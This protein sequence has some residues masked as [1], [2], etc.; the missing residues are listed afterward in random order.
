MELPLQPP[1]TQPQ[2]PV[3][4]QGSLD[5]TQPR[6]PVVQQG[7]PGMGADVT[8]E[9]GAQ[10]VHS[11]EGVIPPIEEELRYDQQGR[12]RKMLKRQPEPSTAEPEADTT[13]EQPAAKPAK[14]AKAAK[15]AATK[16]SDEAPAAAPLKGAAKLDSKKAQSK[17]KTASATTYREGEL[18]PDTAKWLASADEDEA[19]AAK[20]D[21]TAARAATMADREKAAGQAAVNAAVARGAPS[22]PRGEQ[23]AQARAK[24][25]KPLG[26]FDTSKLGEKT[27]SAKTAEPV[28]AKTGPEIIE[29]KKPQA[30]G[31][32]DTSKLG[33]KAEAPAQMPFMITQLMKAQLRA[34]GYKSEAISNMTPADAHT[35]LQG[36]TPPKPVQ[37]ERPTVA[38]KDGEP[39]V[40]VVPPTDARLGGTKVS[41]AARKAGEEA[42]AV[43]ERKKKEAADKLAAETKP[44]DPKNLKDLGKLVAEKEAEPGSISDE[45]ADQSPRPKG[46]GT[47]N[48]LNQIEALSEEDVDKPDQPVKLTR[49]EKAI[50]AAKAIE[51]AKAQVAPNPTDAQKAAG[52]HQM[53]HPPT[54]ATQ[55]QHVTID[56][57]EGKIGEA[58][59]HILGTANNVPAEHLETLIRSKNDTGKFYVI[60]KLKDG[61]FDGHIAVQGATDEAN[62]YDAYI[63]KLRGEHPGMSLRERADRFS[64]VVAMSPTE[65]EHFKQTRNPNEPVYP[66]TEGQHP[67]GEVEI[68]EGVTAKTLGGASSSTAKVALEQAL[69]DLPND[70]LS[71]IKYAIYRK[72]AQQA[73]KYLPDVPIYYIKKSDLAKVSRKAAA[74]YNW[75]RN[76]ILISDEHVTGYPH[77]VMILHEVMHAAME[78][79]YS[80]NKNFRSAIDRIYGEYIDKLP[81]GEIPTAA[82]RSGGAA[83]FL[84]ELANP[85]VHDQMARIQMSKALAEDLDMGAWAKATHTLWN[86]VVKAY[87]DGLE[88][89]GFRIPG[90]DDPSKFTL[91]EGML[92]MNDE[93][94][95]LRNQ[96]ARTD[97]ANMTRA[98]NEH[99]NNIESTRAIEH[100]SQQDIIDTVHKAATDPESVER[101]SA[102]NGASISERAEDLLNK[103]PKGIGTEAYYGLVSKMMTTDLFRMANE[104][105][106][107]KLDESNPLRKY[108]EKT[109]Q[110]ARD[111]EERL[112]VK[113]EFVAKMGKATAEI[114][115]QETEK[116]SDLLSKA[117]AYRF[118]PRHAI[119]QGMNTWLKTAADRLAAARAKGEE[120]PNLFYKHQQAMDKSSEIINDFNN[121][122]PKAR[123]WY[124]R[125]VDDY[126]AKG[127]ERAE[128]TTDALLHTIDSEGKKFVEEPKLDPKNPKSKDAIDY[129]KYHND[130]E[131]NWEKNKA[132]L[133][134]RIL[135]DN[136]TENDTQ[137]LANRGI[138]ATDDIHALSVPKGPYVPLDHA[139]DYLINARYKINV[140]TNAKRINDNTFEFKTPEAMKEFLKNQPPNSRP[141]VVHYNDEG[142]VVPRV[143]NW[144]NADGSMG[145]AKDNKAWRV[146]VNDKY[147]SGH[148]N[149]SSANRRYEELKATGA[150]AKIAEPAMKQS[151]WYNQLEVSSPL[152]KKLIND[153]DKRTDYTADQKNAV[154]QLLTDTAIS[155]MEG[156]RIAKTLLPRKMVAGWDTDFIKTYDKYADMHNALMS[157]NKYA[158]EMGDIQNEMI[159]HTKDNEYK[160]GNTERSS[161]LSELHDRDN[162][163]GSPG[164]VGGEDS[165]LGKK[166]APVLRK[167]AAVSFLNHMVSVGHII[168][169][170]THQILTADVVAAK[171]GG[172]GTMGEAAR[173]HSI[174]SGAGFKNAWKSL[175]EIKNI[176]TKDS[177]GLNYV[178]GLMDALD[179]HRYGAE[180]RAFMEKA[181]ETGRVHPDQ[182]FDTSVYHMS[183]GKLDA[184]SNKLERMSR[185]LLGSTEAYNRV[186]GHALAYI[187]A[188]E[189]GENIEQATRSSFDAVSESQGLLSRANMSPIMSKWYMRPTMQ[190]RG[191][192]MN[193]MMTIART[194]YNAFKG[195]T[196][197]VKAEAWRRIA[198]LFGTTAALTG[199]NGLPSDPM[200]IAL[201]LAG[202]LGITN[203]N[204]SDAQDA[205]RKKFTEL[206]GSGF[207]TLAMDGALGSMGPF[208]FFGADRI[209]FGSLLVFGEPQSASKA[210][211]A[212]WMWA[213]AGGA[214][215]QTLPNAI[216]GVNFLRQGEYARGMAKLVPL[217]VFDDWA[218]AWSGYNEGIPTKTGVPGMSPYS[219][220]E[221]IMQGMGLT[222]ARQERYREGRTAELRAE[223]ADRDE[224]S[225]LLDAL[226]K[227]G[228]TGPESMKAKMQIAAYNLQHPSDRITPQDIMRASRRSTMPSAFGKT[229]T[230]RNRDRLNDLQSYYNAY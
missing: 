9:P 23:P 89:L 38:A 45:D 63:A 11:A 194:F 110:R 137:W 146:E 184:W 96:H 50:A 7:L 152:F 95:M 171:Y 225:Q 90:K 223:Q 135:D 46:G 226:G 132:G 53:G 6:Q 19:P 124:G 120:D 141:Y 153:V 92:R 109:L 87:K 129:A 4:E 12:L 156:N 182:G 116:L 193:M 88:K 221:A 130:F 65:F 113:R 139:G 98:M 48:I 39:K 200:R 66:S 15:A 219:G 5:L 54:D 61:V 37:T 181:I 178:E 27:G 91:L 161:V 230:N 190:F 216:D 127:R 176:I 55:G 21:T 33:A 118:D 168:T 77:P 60:N 47:S 78:H 215:G 68:K 69:R 16:D 71:N 157:R 62:A 35:I 151:G 126:A 147:Y 119:G 227:A 155:S 104:K 217:K 148:D 213:I 122:H 64:G 74:L 58:H 80:T 102:L 56:S 203:Y 201:A 150:F 187:R 145:F 100:N 20:G 22:I 36:K 162:F 158:K 188:R 40:T 85:T 206:G 140:P 34:L 26:T 202:V 52:N 195:E 163:F 209:G 112:N 174:M 17:T 30:K 205:M 94:F 131:T 211:F 93:A 208:G 166:V 128:I 81:K 180:L 179:K 228:P 196:R 44:A 224:H 123:E 76:H 67:F 13:T 218:K 207:A 160:P 229:I 144:Q 170:S 198:Y 10:P 175:G 204:W 75:Q 57:A 99:A 177:K 173:L 82:I 42:K 189:A 136:L 210:D 1:A 72:L 84:A 222:P 18:P 25:G 212:A 107:G 159:K 199:I 154:K 86:G 28:K 70:P 183:S 117:T 49:K 214:P 103:R 2:A 29:S 197:D 125:L 8:H 101:I 167:M 14:P 185:Q 3:P 79:L 134:K 143:E 43:I 165:K 220:G 59:G 111:F 24:S 149:L 97:F 108:V 32:F 133:R 115:R 41:D 172:L 31:T 186:W 121:L 142:K 192:G 106:F 164:Y 83:E 105:F 114:G 138:D 51:D 191:W 73:I 169:H